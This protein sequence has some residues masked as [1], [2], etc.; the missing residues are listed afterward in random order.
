HQLLGGGVAGAVSNRHDPSA[1]V[2]PAV[3][4]PQASPVPT[5]PPDA[6]VPPVAQP[7]PPVASLTGYRWPISQGRVTLP[8]KAIPGGEWFNGTKLWHDGVDMPS[9]CGA[10]VGAAHAG[11]VRAAGRPCDA[12]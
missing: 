3:V 9:F 1:I 2:P 11:T 8:F 4:A 5:Q 10:R 7:A 12:Q 6:V